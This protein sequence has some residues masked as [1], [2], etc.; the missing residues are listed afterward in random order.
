MRRPRWP[1]DRRKPVTDALLNKLCRE[2]VVAHRDCNTCQRCGTGPPHQIQ[3]C[4]VL[5][6]THKWAQ[7]NPLASLALCATDHFWFDSRKGT[8]ARPSEG[9]AWWMEKFPDRAQALMV[10]YAT[11]R[12]PKLDR[13]ALRM[14]LEQQ[15]GRTP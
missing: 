11:K 4:H 15:L 8:L 3:W 14:W 6:R 13:E 2:Y 12:R 5:T 9:L 1:A 7:W 10:L